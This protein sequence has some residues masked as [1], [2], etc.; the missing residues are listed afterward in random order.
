[1]KVILLQD[2]DHLGEKGEIHEVANGYGRNYLIPQGI[3]RLATDGAI[4]QAREEQRQAARKQAA[5]AD[6]AQDLAD[7]LEDMQ[8]VFTAKVGEDNRIFGTV[9]TQQIAVEL[10]NRG[11]EIDRRSIDLDEDIREV[12]TYTAHI[13]LH[14]KVK[15]KLSIQVIPET[16]ADF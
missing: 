6:E 9:T 4:K 15:A 7:E 14:P 2:V 5:K 12:G 11:Y 16:G 3:A 1:M 10:A 8:V 13:Q